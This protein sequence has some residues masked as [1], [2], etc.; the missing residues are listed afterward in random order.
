MEFEKYFPQEMTDRLAG[1]IEK[2]RRVTVTCH[3]S[4]DGDAIGSSLA[5]MRYLRRKGK[6][7]HVVTP[8]T[9]PASLAFLPGTEEIVAGTV[10]IDMARG[11]IAN[12]DLLVCADYSQPPRVGKLSDAVERAKMPVVVIDHHLN[13]SVP[14]ELTFSRPES[15]STC[16]LVFHILAQMGELGLVDQTTSEL[17]LTG[18]MTD[19]GNF[20]Y[21]A[22]DPEIYRVAAWMVA[23]GADKERLC[24]SLFS[25]YSLTSLRLNSYALD[26]KL[27]IYPAHRA[28]VISLTA[29]ELRRFHYVKGDTEGLVNVPLGIPGIVCSIFL[30]EDREGAKVR[31]SV[32]SKGDFP[33]DIFCSTRFDGGGHK[34]AAGGEVIGSIATAVEAVEAVLP[35]FD[36][37][38]PDD[39]MSVA[40][41]D[42]KDDEPDEND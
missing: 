24:R 36:R 26:R 4:P 33:A 38:L 19:T 29:A 21:S 13:P 42:D 9:P 7:V 11:L 8:D 23:R 30:R 3:I 32:R 12:C 25:T 17:L 18:M 41:P 37:Y 22:N 20:S 2:A 27:K 40:V 6:T 34:N 28:A 16:L 1:L 10:N 5:L 31:V 35:E 39:G 15:S 14:A